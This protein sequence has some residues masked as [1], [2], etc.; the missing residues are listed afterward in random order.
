MVGGSEV[1]GQ[2]RLRRTLRRPLHAGEGITAVAAECI[3]ALR[4]R[5]EIFWQPI[6]FSQTYLRDVRSLVRRALTRRTCSTTYVTRAG[7]RRFG[8]LTED[9]H[10]YP[11]FTHNIYIYCGS[12]CAHTSTIWICRT[13]DRIG[14]PDGMVLDPAGLRVRTITARSAA[15]LSQDSGWVDLEPRRAVLLPG[16][17]APHHQGAVVPLGGVQGRLVP[18]TVFLAERP[19]PLPD[20]VHGHVASSGSRSSDTRPPPELSED[21]CRRRVQHHVGHGQRVVLSPPDRAAGRAGPPPGRPNRTSRR[22]ASCAGRSS[23]APGART[24]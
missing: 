7:F 6:W 8:L 13:S 24:P 18:G 5:S 1:Q 17:L 19:E 22:R 21:G 4:D 11:P 14:V 9:S 12:N 23:P 2:S 10:Y 3:F 15:W 16:E 20:P